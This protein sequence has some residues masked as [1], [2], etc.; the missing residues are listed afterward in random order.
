MLCFLMM[1]V[2]FL[3]DQNARSSRQKAVADF[4]L[5]NTLPELQCRNQLCIF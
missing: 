1:R 5:Q 4:Q 2:R 3:G